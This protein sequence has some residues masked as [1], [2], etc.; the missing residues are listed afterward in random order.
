MKTIRLLPLVGAVVAALCLS[1][2]T[3]ATVIDLHQ[4]TIA[5][6]T[7]SPQAQAPT[8]TSPAPTA[9]P[10]VAATA[11]PSPEPTPSEP[12]ALVA[13][14]PINGD[15]TMSGERPIVLEFNQAMDQATLLD[16]LSIE[17]AVELVLSW[18]EPNKAQLVPVGGWT[19]D[20]YQLTL[21]GSAASAGGQTLGQDSVIAFETG[22]YGVPIPIIMYHNIYTYQDIAD[23]SEEQLTWTVSK[24]AFSEQ[25]HYLADNGWHTID[26]GQIAD[27]FEGGTLPAKPIIVSIDDAWISLYTAAWPVFKETGL[28]P[29]VNVVADFPN[30][31]DYED[32]LDWERLRELQKEGV[33]FGAHSYSHM[34]L[35]E[36]SAEDLEHEVVDAKA[37]I[38]KQLGIT[39]ACFCY[40]YGSY[41]DNAIVALQA[42]GFRAGLTL[43]PVTYQDPSEPFRLNRM[44]IDYNTTMEQFMGYLDLDYSRGLYTRTSR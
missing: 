37:E 4:A 32:Y 19:A 44:R 24:E 27:Y 13:S 17:P 22:G 34:G 39:L 36:L 16:N 6:Q 3:K 40:P 25:M 26:S 23:A 30:Y 33:W 41:D 42:A 29:E 21:K 35:Y 1:A 38:E 31:V 15:L 11:T 20:A 10:T 14:N 12:P 9:E 5:A 2:C 28:R 8:D 43:N 18:P 7:A